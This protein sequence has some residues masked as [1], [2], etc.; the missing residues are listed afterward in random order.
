M[1]KLWIPALAGMT[2]WAAMTL[3]EAALEKTPPSQAAQSTYKFTLIAVFAP[4]MWGTDPIP[5]VFAEGPVITNDGIVVYSAGTFGGTLSSIF[6]SDGTV[7]RLIVPSFEHSQTPLITS[8]SGNGKLVTNGIFPRNIIDVHDGTV[9]GQLDPGDEFRIGTGPDVFYEVSINNR[10][11]VAFTGSRLATCSFLGSTYTDFDQGIF[12]FD[13]ATTTTIATL[14]WPYDIGFLLAFPSIN[15]KNQV[16]F[17][18]G[19]VLDLCAITP[20]IEAGSM[21][22]GDGTGLVKIAESYTAPSLN[23]RGEVGFIGVNNGSLSIIVSDGTSTRIVADTNGPFAEFPQYL[24]S[25]PRT[26]ISIND[27]SDVAFM[28]VLDNGDLGIF[29]GPDVVKN[30][31]IAIGDSL[32]G[33]SVSYLILSKQS[34]NNNGQI[35]FQATLADGRMVIV[36]AE[37]IKKLLN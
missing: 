20:G 1:K 3:T 23:N 18:V 29:T 7:T 24:D 4:P 31:V 21:Y 13:G 11:S 16:A 10:G 19:S 32:A 33:S 15:E 22:V 12:R 36:R 28:A 34:L 35:A 37:P 6:S 8:V 26:G 14:G 17:F 25:V 30:K 2:L 27:R 9:L 5:S